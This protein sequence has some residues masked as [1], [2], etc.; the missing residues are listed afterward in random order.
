MNILSIGNS[1]AQD[2]MEFLPAIAADLEEKSVFA[3][4]YIGGCPIGYHYINAL[5]DVP[6]YQYHVHTGGEWEIRDRVSVSEAIQ[7]RQWDWINIQH[8]SKDGRCYTESVYYRH[9]EDLVSIVR[10]LAGP[11]TKISFNMAWVPDPEKEHHEMVRLHH[12]DQQH[13]YDAL[14]ALTQNV[15]VTT[16][17]IDRVSPTG[18]AIQL[19]R[20]AGLPELTRD[21]FH[22]SYGLG[23][24]IAA[25][26]FLH[27]LTGADIQKVQWAPEDVT[28]EM[29]A[30][31]IRCA[32]EANTQWSKI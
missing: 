27:A 16:P 3:Y 25:L 10:R 17:G 31:A 14:V 29:R 1:F 4:L 23:R 13:M 5:D 19:A 24:Y 9:L 8:G 28:P 11:D 20:Q 7:S 18:M 26:T 30:T 15:V 32:L 21:H 12:N 6:V 22:V 2:T